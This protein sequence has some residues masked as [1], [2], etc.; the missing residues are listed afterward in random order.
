M[1]RVVFVSYRRGDNRDFAGRLAD[2]LCARFGA[3]QVFFDVE[4]IEL[5]EVFDAAIRRAVNECPVFVPVIGPGWLSA[6]DKHGRR[7]LDDPHDIV[8]LEIATAL[9]LGKRVIPVLVEGTV[10]PHKEALPEDLAGLADRHG[11][12]VRHESFRGDGTR[13]VAAIENALGGAA[14]K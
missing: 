5:G 7:R 4:T 6:T 3:Q 2:F 9:A 13:L 14:G 1:S 10:M 8:R 11:L 12:Y